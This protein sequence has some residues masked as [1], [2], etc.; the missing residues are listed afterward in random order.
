V[1][2]AAVVTALVLHAGSGTPAPQPTP[3]ASAV[4]PVMQEGR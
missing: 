1:A 3:V 4:V 2:F